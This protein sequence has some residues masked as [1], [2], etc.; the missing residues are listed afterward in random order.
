MIRRLGS[1]FHLAQTLMHIV[2]R[3]AD[4][5]RKQ[6]IRHKVRAGAGGKITAVL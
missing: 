6:F 4:R 5:L 3:L 1:V 2:G